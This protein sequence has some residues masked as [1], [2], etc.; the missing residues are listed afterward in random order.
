MEPNLG[1]WK[2]FSNP[3]I[4]FLISKQYQILQ[5]QNRRGN[6]ASGHLILDIVSNFDIRHSILFRKSE[7][8]DRRMKDEND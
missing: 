8:E 3:N 7:H 4:K 2:R 1:T 5:I 6:V